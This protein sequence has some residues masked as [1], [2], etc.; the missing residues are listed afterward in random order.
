[1]TN[2]QALTEICAGALAM[3][4]LQ[5][6]EQAVLDMIKDNPGIR[7]KEIACRLG[8]TKG[9][10]SQIVADLVARELVVQR[11]LDKGRGIA[12]RP[13]STWMSKR[14]IRRPWSRFREG[15]PGE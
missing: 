1:M 6:T 12:L 2:L 7:A 11:P 8:K 14:L 9:R 4:D 5:T 13:P 10:I 3:G 15:R